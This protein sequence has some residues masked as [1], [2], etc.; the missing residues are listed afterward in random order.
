MALARHA[1][2]ASDQ[3]EQCANTQT[4]GQQ[5]QSG[6]TN[7]GTNQDRIEK[8]PLFIGNATRYWL[9]ITAP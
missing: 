7:G 4:K 1:I 6:G 2:S 3:G 5:D 9:P 8:I